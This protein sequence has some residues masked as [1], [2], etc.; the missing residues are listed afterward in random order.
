MQVERYHMASVN[1]LGETISLFD[2]ILDRI[3]ET[4]CD[5]ARCTILLTWRAICLLTK[6]DFTALHTRF[7][8]LTCTNLPC[9]AFAIVEA[10][11]A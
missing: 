5:P 6:R 4:N 8:V 1:E 10:G 7:A 11:H 3:V 2:A 9:V